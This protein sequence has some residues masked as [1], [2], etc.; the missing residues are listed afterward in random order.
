VYVHVFGAEVRS[1]GHPFSA[2][3][4]GDIEGVRQEG[5]N[6]Q[7]S[8]DCG[9]QPGMD[10]EGECKNHL[11]RVRNPIKLVAYRKLLQNALVPLRTVD[12]KVCQQAAAFGYEA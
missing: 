3:S 5:D 8:A 2:E 7:Y 12:L 1:S 10:H 11:L 4:I 9:S 6:P